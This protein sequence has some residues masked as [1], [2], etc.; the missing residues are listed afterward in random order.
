MPR[1]AY[2]L[3]DGPF[4]LLVIGGG[5]Y[6]AW[7]AYD[8]TLRGL[9]TA[10]V[11]RNDWASG[12]SSASSKLIHGGLRYLE[13]GKFAL[14][15]KALIERGRLMRLAP[16]RVR[17]L[18]FL[19]PVHRDARAGRLMLEAGLSLYDLLAGGSNGKPHTSYSRDALLERYPFLEPRGLRGGF[20]YSDAG[21]D[22]AR[23]TLELVAGAI[24]GGAAAANR[25]EARQC[26]AQPMGG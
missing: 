12:T 17:A 14:V 5:V 7:T 23:F 24:A 18:R 19:L 9:R 16:H 1:G 11:E 3:S 26:C 13:Y 20:A 2:R 4:D 8:A 15:R 22:D 10:L 21:E 6:G 25:C